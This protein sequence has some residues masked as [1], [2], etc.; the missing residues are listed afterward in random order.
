VLATGW[1]P[2]LG[3]RGCGTAARTLAVDA[4]NIYFSVGSTKTSAP[5]LRSMAKT[6]GSAITIAELARPGDVVSGLFAIDAVNAYYRFPETETVNAVSLDGGTP[7][8]TAHEWV[9]MTD[10]V[11]D[12]KQIVWI[13]GSTIRSI[14]L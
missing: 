6:G 12:Q 8:A 5:N 4:S 14:Q 9:S 3:N 10:I 1:A 2:L 7:T 13:S 11:T